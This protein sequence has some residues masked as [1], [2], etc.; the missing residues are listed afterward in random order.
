MSFQANNDGCFTPLGGLW[1]M[2][3]K[4]YQSAAFAEGWANFYAA[5][6]FNAT[7]ET[8][9]VFVN[10]EDQDYD[11]NGSVESEEPHVL[12]CE[13]GPTVVGAKDYYS[14]ICLPRGGVHANRG[15][16][17]DWVRFW[18]DFMTEE[19]SVEFSTC[20]DILD[21]ANPRSWMAESDVAVACTTGCAPYNRLELA[22][23]DLLI[24]D[25]VWDDHLDN[26]V[27]R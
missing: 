26:G 8:D 19:S 13:R 20:L 18:W 23:H 15:V 24:D 16:P 21:N 9:C 7:N 10:Y 11:L 2:Q 17:L 22:A 4:E 1:E 3:Q 5:V 27:G 12:S 25:A 6:A 14:E